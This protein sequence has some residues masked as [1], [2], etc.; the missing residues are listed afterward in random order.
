MRYYSRMA[1]SHLSTTLAVLRAVTGATAAEFAATI[2]KSPDTVKSVESGR[3]ALSDSLAATIANETGVCP[4]WLLAGDPVTQPV[5]RDGELF[6][7]KTFAR[8]REERRRGEAEGRAES[9]AAADVI[10][11]LQEMLC[12]FHSA[13]G[14]GDLS[15][16]SLRLHR[17][18]ES[19]KTEFG[20]SDFRGSKCARWC[21]DMAGKLA[22]QVQ[23]SSARS[24][25]AYVLKRS[26][27]RKSSKSGSPARQS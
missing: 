4:R 21:G 8:R 6:T 1:K 22:E 14:R 11:S 24:G 20:V 12:A 7:L 19:L 25:P 10:L 16:A 18:A 27:G 13:A 15:L 3:L 5:D 2:G 26:A 23:K 9:F 17:F